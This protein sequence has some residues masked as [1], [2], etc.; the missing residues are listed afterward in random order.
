MS[1]KSELKRKAKELGISSAGNID[2]LTA[3]IAEAEGLKD[4]PADVPET[5]EDAGDEASEE[6]S[7]D[8]EE[9]SDDAS[10]SLVAEAGDGRDAQTKSDAPPPAIPAAIAVADAATPKAAVLQK[11]AITNASAVATVTTVK[12]VAGWRHLVKGKPIVAPASV[13]S[14]LRTCGLVE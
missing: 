11:S 8:T 2:D 7:P 14:H 3:R 6:G 1:L 9:G 13:I 4:E 12:F 10:D 5:P